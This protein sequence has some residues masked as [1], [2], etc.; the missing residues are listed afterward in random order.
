MKKYIVLELFADV[1]DG[2]R[3]YEP[4][5]SYPRA[6]Y[7][8]SEERIEELST[9]TNR[10]GRPVIKVV[11]EKPPVVEEKVEEPPKAS[12]KKTSKKK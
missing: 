10:R 2:Y 1:Q 5:D 7:E 4:G 12:P 11:E 8:P 9:D 3:N 6:G